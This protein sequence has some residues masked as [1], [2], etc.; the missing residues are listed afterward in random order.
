MDVDGRLRGDGI[1]GWRGSRVQ[2][3]AVV[4]DGMRDRANRRVD[5]ISGAVD[6]GAL[7]QTNLGGLVGVG[8]QVDL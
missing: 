3:A 4:N 7:G 8:R 5:D 6:W 1:L 2:F